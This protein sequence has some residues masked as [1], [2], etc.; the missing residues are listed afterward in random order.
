[1]SIRRLITM[2]TLLCSLSKNLFVYS[3]IMDHLAI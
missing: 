3:E 2:E 1:M